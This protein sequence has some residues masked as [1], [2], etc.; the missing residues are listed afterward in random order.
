MRCWHTA[1]AQ[2][3]MGTVGLS[4]WSRLRAREREKEREKE[5]EREREREREE[6]GERGERDLTASNHSELLIVV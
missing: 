4:L 1:Y 5:R 2:G 6:R 3:L